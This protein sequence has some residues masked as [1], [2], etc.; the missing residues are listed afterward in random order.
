MSNEDLERDLERGPDAVAKA[1]IVWRKATH[2]KKKQEALLYARLKGEAALEGKE[3]STT[4]LKHLIN[5]NGDLYQ[6]ILAEIEA[7]AEYERV[8]EKHLSNKKRADIRKAF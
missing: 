4:D 8:Y 7:E 6:F 1:L 3:L 2:E 5:S